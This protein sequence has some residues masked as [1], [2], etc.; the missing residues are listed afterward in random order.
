[1]QKNRPV[2]KRIVKAN[3]VNDGGLLKRNFIDYL[4]RHLFQG[5]PKTLMELFDLVNGDYKEKGQ[6][7]MG[8]GTFVTKVHALDREGWVKTVTRK[9][10]QLG[11]VAVGKPTFD[12]LSE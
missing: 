9:D 5:S 1:M 8:Y 2:G 3:E 7:A 10:G 6:V 4:W 12:P 11:F